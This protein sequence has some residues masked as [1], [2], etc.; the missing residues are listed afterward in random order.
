MRLRGLPELLFEPPEPSRLRRLLS[1]RLLPVN[2]Q[3][4]STV[5]LRIVALPLNVM[6]WCYGGAEVHERVEFFSSKFID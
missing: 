3:Q 2:T 4:T 5:K 1:V 6:L